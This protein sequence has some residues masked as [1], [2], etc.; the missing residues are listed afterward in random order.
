MRVALTGTPGTGKTSASR[1]LRAPSRVVHLNEVIRTEGFVTGTDE[2]RDTAVVDM[3]AVATWLGQTA[4]AQRADRP[5]LVESHLAHQ[6]PAD[7]VVVLRCH[8]A[9]LAERLEGRA[10]DET[11]G[12]GTPHSH[13]S[14][15]ENAEAEALDLVLSE[16]VTEHGAQ[17]VHEI[18]TTDQPIQAVATA[19]DAIVR[20]D[21]S[22]AIGT[23]DYT[24]WLT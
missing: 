8:P 18:E 24:G 7:A 6:F 17:N 10:S 19:V 23:V 15:H 22:T 3:D 2:D 16:A 14:V 12:S 13:R 5:V 9:T 1:V 20:G 21:R 11:T 4:E